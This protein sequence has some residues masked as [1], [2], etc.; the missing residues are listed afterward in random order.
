MA[1]ECVQLCSIYE[2]FMTG[3]AGWG[4]EGEEGTQTWYIFL[5]YIFG[6]LKKI[7]VLI[8]NL[9]KYRA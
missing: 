4:G 1:C 7:K 2:L 9:F 8:N 6:N 5:K 3:L